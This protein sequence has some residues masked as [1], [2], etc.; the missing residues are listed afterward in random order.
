[1]YDHGA[2]IS[3]AARPPP[4]TASAAPRRRVTTW[5]DV[6]DAAI[7]GAHAGHEPAIVTARGAAM[8]DAPSGVAERAQLARGWA[9]RGPSKARM[10]AAVRAVVAEC[11]LRGLR[12]KHQK[13]SAEDAIA[14]VHVRCACVRG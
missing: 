12:N 9:V 6:R 8:G 3:S 5:S 11:F 10:S 1:M 4:P 13:V 14:I 2:A 7:T